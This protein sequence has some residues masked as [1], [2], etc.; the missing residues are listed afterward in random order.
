MIEREKEVKWQEYLRKQ[1]QIV[2]WWKQEFDLF[3]DFLSQ[4]IFSFSF[5]IFFAFTLFMNPLKLREKTF[6]AGLIWCQKPVENPEKCDW[7]NFLGFKFSWL[8]NFII[9]LHDKS[10]CVWNFRYFDWIFI[11][12]NKQETGDWIYCKRSEK[13]HENQFIFDLKIQNYQNCCCCRM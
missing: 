1:I 13:A 8:T 4:F 11:E 7:F 10:N 9:T 2:L 12:N 6:E 5:S 3:E